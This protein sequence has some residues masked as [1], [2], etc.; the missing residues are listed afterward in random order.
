MTV[1]I[2]LSDSDAA[3]LEELLDLFGTQCNEQAEDSTDRLGAAVLADTAEKCARFKSAVLLARRLAA[4]KT[5]R[6]APSAT[7][8]S[9]S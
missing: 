1:S 3:R 7:A 6:S 8:A 9:G 4:E 5:P 2:L